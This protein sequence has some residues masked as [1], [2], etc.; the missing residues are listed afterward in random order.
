MV[1]AFKFPGRAQRDTSIVT[2]ETARWI[3]G[4]AICSVRIPIT[5][6]R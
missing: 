3:A 6:K 1:S 2:M 4:N 5:Q